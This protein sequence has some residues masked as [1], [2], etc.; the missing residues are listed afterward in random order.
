MS[1]MKM[2]LSGDLYAIVKDSSSSEHLVPSE[3]PIMVSAEIMRTKGRSLSAASLAVS[4]VLL[5]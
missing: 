4:T 2:M 1:S 5:T 3:Q